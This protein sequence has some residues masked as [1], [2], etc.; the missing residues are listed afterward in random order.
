MET[1]NDAPNHKKPLSTYCAE[2]ENFRAS[3]I[4]YADDGY[5]PILTKCEGGRILIQKRINGTLDFNRNYREY[6]DGFGDPF[7][8]FWI[9]NDALHELTK[10]NCT[11][12]RID[13][14]D[15]IGNHWLASYAHFHVGPADSGYRLKVGGFSGNASN[16]L[17]FQNDMEF[18]TVDKDHDTSRNHCAASYQGGWW[19]SHCQHANLN[20]NYQLGLTWF[21]TARNEWIAMSGSRMSV[22]RRDGCVGV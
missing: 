21:N 8:E 2:N 20:G 11:T 3:T 6:A 13:M 9:G 4:L 19:F 14:L 1:E 7:A 17:A 15:T 22:G 10:D 5:T 12:L 16:A 18:S